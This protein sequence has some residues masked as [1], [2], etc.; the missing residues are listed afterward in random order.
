MN[1]DQRM[2]A[3]G[4]EAENDVVG[5]DDQINNFIKTE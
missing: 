2:F 4:D 1:K 3:L 5:A